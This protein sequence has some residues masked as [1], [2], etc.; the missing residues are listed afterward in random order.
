MN[1]DEVV[2]EED[3]AEL[4]ASWTGIPVNTM[5]EAETAKLLQMETRLHERVVGR[6]K[7]SALWRTRSVVPG[8]G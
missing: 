7:R 4:I 5:M 8:P 3:I 2:D 6:M 1:L